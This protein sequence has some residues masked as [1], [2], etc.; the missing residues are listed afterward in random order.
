MSQTYQ[1]NAK[2][3][4]GLAALQATRVS[5]VEAMRDREKRSTLMPTH[6]GRMNSS[7]T[8]IV[9]TCG[10]RGR[11]RGRGKKNTFFDILWDFFEVSKFCM[12][13]QSYER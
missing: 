5:V 2:E 13:C 9:S 8:P 3:Y 10:G 1:C 7:K 11:E 12:V 4:I 6:R